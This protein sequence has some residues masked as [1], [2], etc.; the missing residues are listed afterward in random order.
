VMGQQVNNR[1]TTA[2]ASLAAAIVIGLNVLLL[3]RVAG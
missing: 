3:A 1:L 2:L